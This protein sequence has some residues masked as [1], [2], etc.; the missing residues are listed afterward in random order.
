MSF[1]GNLKNTADRLIR[2]KGQSITFTNTSTQ[3]Y[4]PS[5]GRR[6]FT[7]ES[8]YTVNAVAYPVNLSSTTDDINARYDV[9]LIAQAATYTRG[10]TCTYL[11]KK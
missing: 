6:E 3:Q 4:D 8:Q 11:G 10:D 1:Y 2:E 5:A 7:A 9:R